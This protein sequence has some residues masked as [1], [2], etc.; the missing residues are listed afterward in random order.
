VT[1]NLASK[2]CAVLLALE[3]SLPEPRSENHQCHQHGD[4]R[5]HDDQY[6]YTCGH[7]LRIPRIGERRP[8]ISIR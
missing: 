8:A 1:F 6:H 5:N 3:L 7:A 2:A 4:D